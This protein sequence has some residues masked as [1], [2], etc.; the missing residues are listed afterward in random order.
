M[1][2]PGNKQQALATSIPGAVS[3]M[4]MLFQRRELVQR[5]CL[6]L[7]FT[8]QITYTLPFLRTMWQLSQSFLTDDRTFMPRA[9]TSDD[10][11][12]EGWWCGCEQAFN[13]RAVCG[14]R[15]RV[16]RGLLEV[17]IARSILDF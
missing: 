6:C 11:G 4:S 14:A 17:S 16:S 12:V 5:T 10:E 7:G 3:N 13:W 8:E 15:R 2:I 1:L 9:K